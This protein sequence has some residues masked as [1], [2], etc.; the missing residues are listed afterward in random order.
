MMLLTRHHA[1]LN[2]HTRRLDVN[3]DTQHAVTE[4]LA[5]HVASID[6][7]SLPADVIERAQVCLLDSLGCMLG[8][9]LVP[10]VRDT[11]EFV[12]RLGDAP[13]VA[14][15][16]LDGL[17]PTPLAAHAAT[18]FGNALDYD[19]TVLGVG[20]PGAGIIATAL[21][22]GQANESS[23]TDLLRAVIAGYE[24]SVRIGWGM[25]PSKERASTVRGHTWAVLGPTAV[26]AALMNLDED[27]I[28]NAFGFAAQHALVPYVGKWY[29]RPITPLKNNYGWAALGGV[30]SASMAAEGFK[31]NQR[32]FDGENGFWRMASSDQW[33][34]E[35]ALAGIGTDWV[36][37]AVEFKPFAACRYTHSALD[38]LEQILEHHAPDVSAIRRVV[39]RAG[40]RIK[41]FA[42]YDARTLLDAQFSLPFAAAS[43]VLVRPLTSFD[44]KDRELAQMARRVQLEVDPDIEP[45]SRESRLPTSVEIELESGERLRE[46]S[47]VALGDPKRPLKPERLLAKFF[48]LAMPVIGVERAERMAGTV[49]NLPAL[50]SARDLADLFGAKQAVTG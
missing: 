39:I 27:Q 15:P 40:N 3:M 32:I 22:V 45:R 33:D 8:G 48:D 6:A 1:D 18:Q 20:H 43:T 9:S 5:A 47:E 50:R 12:L 4:R 14:I 46:H 16:G 42:D 37:R 34:P 35:R 36:I 31:T 38:A 41:V 17:Y 49:D 23:G 19:D 24:T 28:V 2:R 13:E 30:L 26:A 21:A 7:T 29:E 25:E 10:E 44:P 11:V